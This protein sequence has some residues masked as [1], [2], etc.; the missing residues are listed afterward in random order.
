MQ[1]A[2]TFEINSTT[3]RLQKELKR[4]FDNIENNTSNLTKV[5]LE[6]SETLFRHVLPY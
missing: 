6:Y 3:E 4:F 5:Y 2:A 1:M